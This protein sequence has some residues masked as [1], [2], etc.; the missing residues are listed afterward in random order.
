MTFPCIVH[1]RAARLVSLHTFVLW[2]FFFCRL[3]A[4][5][6]P[7]DESVWGTLPSHT[8]THI[9]QS[10]TASF[11]SQL[12]V[13]NTSDLF[14][15]GSSLTMTLKEKSH[16]VLSFITR[17]R[18]RGWHVN[19]A[20]SVNTCQMNERSVYFGRRAAPVWFH[21]WLDEEGWKQAEET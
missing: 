7:I 17:I 9:E 3:R 12:T 18:V 15:K 21:M 5:L 10:S 16:C 6:C 20:S 2:I 19:L 1:F 4:A 11:I 14:F 8:H 13:G